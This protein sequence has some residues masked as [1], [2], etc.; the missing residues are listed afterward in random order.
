[1][2][3]VLALDAYLGTWP[4]CLGGTCGTHCCS[5]CRYDGDTSRPTGTHSGTVEGTEAGLPEMPTGSFRAAAL[6][7]CAPHLQRRAHLDWRKMM[8]DLGSWAPLPN[9]P[10]HGPAPGV[11]PT[12]I[13]GPRGGFLLHL[14]SLALAPSASKQSAQGSFPPSKGNPE[15]RPPRGFK[16]LALAEL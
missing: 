12:D 15:S 14:P 1:M 3:L 13:H 4:S 6:T 10:R 7:Q 8:L 9:P 2:L 16:A 5:W 11:H